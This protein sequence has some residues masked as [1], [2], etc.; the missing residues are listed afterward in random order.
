MTVARARVLLVLLLVSLCPDASVAREQVVVLTSFPFS[1]YSQYEIAFEERHPNIDLSFVQRNTAHSVRTL[2]E[3]E[4]FSSDVF[5]ASAPDAF[6]VLKAADLL[7][8]TAPRPTGAPGDFGG[9]PLNDV[10]GYYVGFALS[11]Y[12]FVYN[13]S[14]LAEHGIPPPRA[15]SDLTQPVYAGHIGISSPAR[16]GTTHLMIE[17]ML[18]TYGW[19]RGWALLS[20]LGGNLSTVTAR[21]FGVASGVAHRRF[22]LGI[23]IDFLALNS[24]LPAEDTRFVLPS[25]TLVIPAS[26][27][28]LK[29]AG[30]ASGAN[31]FVD[32]VLSEAGQRI[33]MHPDIRRVP[34]VPALHGQL[35]GIQAELVMSSRLLEHQ[36]FDAA[37]SAKRYLML[38]I[39]FE[40]FIVRHRA[41]LARAWKQ[42]HEIESVTLDDAQTQQLERAIELLA[43][44]PWPEEDTLDNSGALRLD[45]IPASLPTSR[46]QS[47]LRASIRSKLARR[48]EA[49]SSILLDLK[50]AGK[51]PA[52]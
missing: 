30:N 9:Y 3:N 12:G 22:G 20:R 15:F 21:S 37:L 42:V 23:T 19:Q 17:A 14:Y 1:F 41:K 13:A 29:R 47:D 25:K 2:K 18:Q 10:D 27:A 5:W 31:V 39:L 48:F 45:D 11:G 52:R 36:L 49:A 16:S 7:Q 40:E 4:D 24:D 6:E 35:T 38:N 28:V 44:P 34:I 50:E 26:I 46:A 32:F 8:P 51:A 43:S 33:L